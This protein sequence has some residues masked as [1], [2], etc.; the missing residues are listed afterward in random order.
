MAPNAAKQK[1]NK[2]CLLSACPR[3]PH[4]A[5]APRVLPTSSPHPPC[6][7]F[8]GVSSSSPL[9]LPFTP[10][11]RV[12][13]TCRV[14]APGHRD[15]LLR[16]WGCWTRPCGARSSVR[17]GRGSGCAGEPWAAGLAC[18]S[19]RLRALTWNKLHFKF[20]QLS[21]SSLPC[22]P[23][24]KVTLHSLPLFFGNLSRQQIAGGNYAAC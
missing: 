21:L 16:S 1:I 12:C 8:R 7:P 6:Q 20:H 11:C 17:V 23:A 5:R 13:G 19:P 15:T 3:P 14:P 10:L 4:P 9:D 18:A 2:Q 22:S 24:N